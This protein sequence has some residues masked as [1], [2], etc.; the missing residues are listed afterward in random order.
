MLGPSEAPIPVFDPATWKDWG[1]GLIIV[2]SNTPC[3]A[4][5]EEGPVEILTPA[6]GDPVEAPHETT[7]DDRLSGSFSWAG[8]DRFLDDGIEGDNGTAKGT[9]HGTGKHAI[10]MSSDAGWNS[11][12]DFEVM[13]PTTANE[14]EQSRGGSVCKPVTA[15][16]GGSYEDLGE[17][18]AGAMTRGRRS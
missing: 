9:S 2:E 17:T 15:A 3:D 4:S 16:L 7:D 5:E 6:S 11:E 8:S 1:S 14:S 10:E 18:E 12:N 13:N